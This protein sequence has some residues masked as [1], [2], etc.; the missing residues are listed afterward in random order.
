MP[1]FTINKSG[2]GPSH[3]T[4]TS[5][6]HRFLVKIFNPLQ[7]DILF[8]AYKFSIPAFEFDR[9]VMHHKQEEIYLPG[10]SRYQGFEMALYRAHNS[11]YD[12]VASQIYDWRSKYT[13]DAANSTLTDVNG[14]L[15][16]RNGQ[17]DVYDGSGNVVWRYYLYGIWPQRT[18]PDTFD[19]QA[20]EIAGITIAGPVD[21]IEEQK[22]MQGGSTSIAGP[23]ATTIA[24]VNPTADRTVGKVAANQP[25]LQ[26][27]QG[28]GDTRVLS[29]R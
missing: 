17:V 25:A 29:G 10:K 26:G 4:E 16:K 9:I 6:K 19:A 20:N 21:K 18:S 1:G 2:G 3:T 22:P 12:Q 14:S 8:Y 24:L 7:S 23:C 28:L 13:L 5:R 27:S 15:P 11:N